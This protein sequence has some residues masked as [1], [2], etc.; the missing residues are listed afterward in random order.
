MP[1]WQALIQRIRQYVALQNK[2]KNL[3]G[4]GFEDVIAAVV[5]RTCRSSPLEVSARRPLSQIPGFNPPKHG[6]KP[7]KV[8]VAIVRPS[9]RTLVTAKWSLRADR[10]KQFPAEFNEYV[11]ANSAGKPFEYVF[12]TNE[13][14]PARL[15]RAC[16]I[17]HGNA[18]MFTHVV[19]I[20]TDAVKATYGTATEESMRK[21][22]GHI[23][24]QRL[25]SVEHW[26]NLLA[27]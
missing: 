24:T 11:T 23:D 1:K 7:N 9:M 26:L 27:T 18:P 8:D 22:L 3:V 6:D 12:V 5:R 19:H 4:E 25:I 16:Q 21:V 13:F 10:E 2:R 15:M 14:D 17:M 20:S